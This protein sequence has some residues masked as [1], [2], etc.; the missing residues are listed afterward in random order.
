M[1]FYSFYIM[2]KFPAR[3]KCGLCSKNIYT[4]DVILICNL[5]FKAYHAKCLQIDT[6]TALELQSHE[7]WF[8]P[9]CIE[10]ILPIHCAD[11]VQ[12]SDTV[13]YCC[14]KIV[15]KSRHQISHCVFCD[16]ICH[17]SCLHLPYMNCSNCQEPQNLDLSSADILNAL[18]DR[19]IFNPY[20][21]IDDEKDSDHFLMMKSTIIAIQ[22]N[23]PTKFYLPVSIMM[24]TLFRTI[25]LLVHRSFS[26]I[27]MDF[28]QTLMSLRTK[29]C[30]DMRQ[31]LISIASMKQIS[32]PM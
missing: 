21:E 13:C 3:E 10:H 18:F 32:N 4:H 14:N 9:N 28:N 2:H 17:T 22:L 23:R 27:L 29:L 20:N 15:S 26:I 11:I 16:N 19:V 7:N 8:C 5:D 30:M 31:I 1:Y 12:E 6:D 25:I 24:H